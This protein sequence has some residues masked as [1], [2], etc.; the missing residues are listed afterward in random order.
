MSARGERKLKEIGRSLDRMTDLLMRDIDNMVRIDRLSKEARIEEAQ[1]DALDASSIGTIELH[2]AALK[3]Y[4]QTVEELRG[5][6]ERNMS[7]GDGDTARVLRELVESVIVHPPKTRAKTD[8]EIKG[9][10]AALTG[11]PDVLLRRV[12]GSGGSGGG[13]NISLFCRTLSTIYE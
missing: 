6:V 3:R 13:T 7:A 11:L 2:P 5:L 10:L 8:I 9:R 1:L 4:L 12:G